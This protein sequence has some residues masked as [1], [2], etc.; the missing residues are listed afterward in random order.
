M[1]ETKKIAKGLFCCVGFLHGHNHIPCGKHTKSRAFF[2]RFISFTGVF[3]LLTS[4]MAFTVSAADANNNEFFD[5]DEYAEYFPHD[6]GTI[7]VNVNIPEDWFRTLIY[8]KNYDGKNFK[9]IMKGFYIPI[10]FSVIGATL[11]IRP[12]GGNLFSGGAVGQQVKSAHFIDLRYVPQKTKIHFSFFVS[13]WYE[14]GWAEDAEEFDACQALYFVDENGKVVKRLNKYFKPEV[15]SDGANL[16]FAYGSSVDLSIMEIP[17]NAVGLIPVFLLYDTLEENYQINYIQ[18]DQPQF[19]FSMTD[20]ES[21]LVLNQ[22]LQN[23]KTAVQ[24]A[25]AEQSEKL[26]GLNN[27]V[28]QLPDQIGDQMQNVMDTEKEESKNEGN[29]FV[30]Q[31][32]DKLPDPSQGILGAL[33]DLTAAINYTGTDAHLAIPAIV[34]PG[35]DGL[36]PEIEIWGGTEFSFSEYVEIL[37]PGLLTLVKSLFTI[38]I[39]LFCVFELK[40]IISYCLTLREKDGG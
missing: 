36:F 10:D 7:G 12:L 15:I 29:K 8:E 30:D 26:D 18:F 22:R 1:S 28:D 39:V 20:L 9:K 4:L 17:D 24:S 23:L 14:S 33:G 21:D 3:V 16:S 37:P 11:T 34:L 13:M 35:I 32:L 5:F 19:S 40:G 25:L 27:K 31:I 38:A 2:Q 6:D